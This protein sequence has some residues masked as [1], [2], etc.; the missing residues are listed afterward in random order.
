MMDFTSFDPYHHRRN[1]VNAMMQHPTHYHTISLTQPVCMSP[2]SSNGLPHSI[3]D[4]SS[5]YNTTIISPYSPHPLSSTY[6]TQLRSSTTSPLGLHTNPEITSKSRPN[7]PLIVETTA[8]SPPV[9]MAFE[10]ASIHGNDCRNGNY[11][12]DKSDQF[13]KTKMCIPFTRGQC[14]RGTNCW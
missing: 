8:S 1:I 7:H 12:T 5:Q 14:K 11:S 3:H 10:L 4:I 13:F 2:Y 9:P 6:N